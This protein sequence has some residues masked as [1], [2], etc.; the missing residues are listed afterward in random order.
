[1]NLLDETLEILARHGKTAKDIVAVIGEDKEGVPC[2]MSVAEFLSVAN[3]EYDSGYGGHEV[4]L[5]LKV[6]GLD[7]WLERGEY[8]GSEWWEFKRMP[9]IPAEGK[10]VVFV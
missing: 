2:R 5:Y 9:K 4:S 1:M 6:V 8:D 10:V 3:K 7:W